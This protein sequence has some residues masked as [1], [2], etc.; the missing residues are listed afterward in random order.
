M[1]LS[2]KIYNVAKDLQLTSCATIT[3]NGRPWVR[4]V[5]GKMDKDLNFR[6]SMQLSSRKAAQ[7]K[8]NPHI[9]LL[10]GVSDPASLS[11]WLQIAGTAEIST[12]PEEKKAFWYEQLADIF[13]D[14]HD[15]DYAVAIIRPSLIEYEV[16]GQPQAEILHMQLNNC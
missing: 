5:L 16:L 12:D 13:S 7:L 1:N 8:N 9:H 2:Q 11:P 4:Y 10:C 6:F 14:V 15:P 3:E